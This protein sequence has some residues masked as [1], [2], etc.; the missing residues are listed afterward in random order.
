MQKFLSQTLA[1]CTLGEINEIGFKKIKCSG[2]TGEGV[3]DILEAIIKNLPAPKGTQ[4][5]KSLIFNLRFY[6]QVLDQKFIKK[7]K[8]SLMVRVLH[9]QN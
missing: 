9:T 7:C 3:E 8:R 1:L 5:E 6:Q 4:E 2:K